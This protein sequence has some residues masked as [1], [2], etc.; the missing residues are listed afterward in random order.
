MARALHNRFALKP[1][2]GP[3]G[4][5]LIG[6]G[7]WGVSNAVNV[8]QSGRFNVVG[9]YDIRRDVACR[10]AHRYGTACYDTVDALLAEPSIQAVS[11]TVPNPL[12]PSF[13]RAA[14]S[15]GKHVF[16]EKPLASHSDA[17]EEL[18]HLCRERGV[19]LLV[20]HQMRR[21]PVFREVARIVRN[22]TLGRPLFA[23]G[24][25]S[26]KRRSR[27]DWRSNPA[28]CPGGSM[29]QLGVHLIDLLMVLFGPPLEARGWSENTPP[30]SD[31]PDWGGVSIAF[32]DG[33]HAIVSTSF[34][35]Q[36]HIRVELFFDEGYL[37][38]DG[39]SIW[40]RR[41]VSTM[42]KI[43]PRGTPGGVAQFVEFADCIERGV[44]PETDAVTA[45]AVMRVVDSIHAEG[46]K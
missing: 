13:V 27:S 15:T 19:V 17:C 41:G 29:E 24:V 26:L 32:A 14:A 28:L 9:V 4:I 21:E 1:D 7:G 38:S 30:R 31:A 25:Y 6:V 18:G 45:A 34:S 36:S 16:I 39:K 11:I 8:M 40:V 23:Q 5:G 10:F 33:I 42:R 37:V 35:S 20:G 44:P 3:I 22:G 43:T 2:R 46:K 12:H